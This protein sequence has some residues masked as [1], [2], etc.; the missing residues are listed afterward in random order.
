MAVKTIAANPAA[1]PLTPIWEPLKAP[2]MT[3]PTIPAIKPENNG[4]PL[5]RAIHKQSGKATKKTTILAGKSAFKFLKR[6]ELFINNYYFLVKVF[7]STL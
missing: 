7:T 2:T 3:P 1:G 4:A 6:F 5:A